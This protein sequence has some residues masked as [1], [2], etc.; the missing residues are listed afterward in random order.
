[1]NIAYPTEN[2]RAYLVFSKVLCGVYVESHVAV[3]DMSSSTYNVAYVNVEVNLMD[4]SKNKGEQRN[5]NSQMT[6][7]QI[8]EGLRKGVEPIKAGRIYSTE[9]VDAILAKELGI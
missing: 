2:F 9:E 5:T 3:D 8:D 1:M 6:N 4:E 7:A